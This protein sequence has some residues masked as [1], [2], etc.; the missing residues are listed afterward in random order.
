MLLLLNVADPHFA[1]T[2]F[3]PRER[4]EIKLLLPHLIHVL[5]PITFIFAINHELLEVNIIIL[6][7]CKESHQ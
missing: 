7:F 2:I 6:K 5:F 3:P 1:Q 4:S